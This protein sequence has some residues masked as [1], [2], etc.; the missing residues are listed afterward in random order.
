MPLSDVALLVLL[1]LFARLASLG[2]LCIR[3]LGPLACWSPISQCRARAYT[4]SVH[5]RP[6]A[7]IPGVSEHAPPRLPVFR[8][9]IYGTHI[10]S[11]RALEACCIDTGL[12]ELIGGGGLG[13]GF[14]HVHVAEE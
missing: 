14:V 5:S 10:H 3:R 7:C 13:Q 4:L 12:D 1:S 6:H 2:A 11:R 9:S 8:Q